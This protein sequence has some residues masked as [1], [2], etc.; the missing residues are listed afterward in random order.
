[1]DDLS[2][3]SASKTT[4][5][6]IARV[7]HT[8]ITVT[9]LERSL[10]FWVG[11]LGFKHLYTTDYPNSPLLEGI[12]GV[13]GAAL[14]LAMVEGPGHNIELIEYSSPLGREHM[15]PR[16]CDVGS[17][18]I[19]FLV[20]DIEALFRRI[21]EHGWHPPGALQTVAD[22]DRKGLKLAYVRGPDGVTLEFL[23]LPQA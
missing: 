2:L 8:G 13:P 16:S 15:E 21:S 11:V 23:E 22:G 1:M 17:V 19:A 3:S 10:E 7:D 4:A 12:V 18:H 6:V 20:N 14:R 9:S 5:G